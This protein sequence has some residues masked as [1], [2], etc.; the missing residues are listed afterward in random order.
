MSTIP[1]PLPS[2][3]ELLQMLDAAFPLPFHFQTHV[4]NLGI[5]AG[6]D[7]PPADMATLT[8][9]AFQLVKQSRI[10][11]PAGWIANRREQSNATRTAK[12]ATSAEVAGDVRVRKDSADLGVATLG[13]S[14][15]RTS[16]PALTVAA[17]ETTKAEVLSRAKAAI[18]AGE[19]S[20]REA[21]EALALAQ[22]DFNATQRE[23]ADAVGR[24]ASW[25]NRLLKWHRSG[26]EDYSPFGPTTQTARV[27]HAKQASER[28]R[29]KTG[30]TKTSGDAKST[31]NSADSATSSS[32]KP[33]ASEAKCNLMSAIRQWWPYIDKVGKAE[34]TSFLLQQ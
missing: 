12:A 8:E 33:S 24:S 27:S 5:S 6:A 21:A 11:D 14:V 1:S 25:V 3:R 9:R 22:K 10:K 28:R 23:M 18:D 19:S 20:L 30:A 32:G 7:L 16:D 2:A 4:R 13:Q 17:R 26:F 29:S 34:V 15:A 31:K